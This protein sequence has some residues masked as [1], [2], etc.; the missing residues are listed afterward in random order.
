MTCNCNHQPAPTHRFGFRNLRYPKMPV[1]KCDQCGV[2]FTTVVIPASLGSSTE[3]AYVP[4]DGMYFNKLVRYEADKAVYI[5]DS[6]GVY[7]EL[8]SA[9]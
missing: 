4:K 8:R 7:S 2:L 9:E 6:A 3:G 5:Y 1:A